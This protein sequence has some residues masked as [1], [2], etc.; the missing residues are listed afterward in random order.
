MDTMNLARSG[1]FAAGA[2]IGACAICLSAVSLPAVAGSKAK[3]ASTAKRT[4]G[5]T[6]TVRT[7]STNDLYASYKSKWVTLPS[8]NY[9][10]LPT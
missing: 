9:Y 8:I 1:R 4:C 3:H 7:A 5:S 6:T 2:I 10:G